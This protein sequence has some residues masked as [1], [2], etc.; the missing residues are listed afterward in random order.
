MKRT[1]LYAALFA[2]GALASTTPATRSQQP[3]GTPVTPDQQFVTKAATAGMAEVEMAKMAV[4]QATNPMVKKFA[5][6]MAD[7]HGR[8]N[9]ELL[10]IAA[11]KGFTVP[12][13]L[14][15]KHRDMAQRMAKLRGPAF[16]RAYMQD[17]V[18]DH[19]EAVRLFENQSKNGRDPALKEF[20]AKTLPTIRE[21]LKMAREI[22]GGR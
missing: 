21:H 6:R 20:A 2:L 1:M 11:D 7:D 22:T 10:K 5:Q 18:K 4:D 3:K 16:D 19:M 12:T 8:A 9:K 17:Q 13:E 15:K 14:D